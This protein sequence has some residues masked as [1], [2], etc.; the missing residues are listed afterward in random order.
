[1][2]RRP[3]VDSFGNFR[4]NLLKVCI[5]EFPA[6]TLEIEPVIVFEHRIHGSTY[7]FGAYGGSS[8]ISGLDQVIHHNGDL[9]DCS[10]HGDDGS[11][12]HM[13]NVKFL[14]RFLEELD[15]RGQLIHIRY[16]D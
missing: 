11:D 9:M 16:T 8:G 3:S 10:G 7:G 4:P 12:R 2:F 6:N 14:C 5:G 15:I 13:D 1:M